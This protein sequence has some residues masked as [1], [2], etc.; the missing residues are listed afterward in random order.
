[1]NSVHTLEEVLKEFKEVFQDELGMLK[2]VTAKIYTDPGATPSFYSARPVPY[3]ALREKVEAGL[4]RLQK[5]G[6]Y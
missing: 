5:A 4:E 6:H 2:R 1:M 3:Y